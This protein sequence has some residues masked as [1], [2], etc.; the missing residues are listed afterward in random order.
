M[1]K[2]AY[3]KGT[4]SISA[5]ETFNNSVLLQGFSN[6][7]GNRWPCIEPDYSSYIDAKQIR[8]MSRIIRMSVASSMIA[9]KQAAI[10]KPDAV[11][12]GTAFGC[13]GDTYSFLSKL[14]QYKEDMLSPTAFI[15]STHN[16][17]ASQIALHYKCY[18]YNSTYVHRNNSYESALSDALLMIENNEV[19]N[20][21]VGGSDETIDAGFTIMNRMGFFKQPTDV[22]SGNLF[23]ENNSGTVA[24]EG[25]S[26]FAL[27][28][29]PS[30]NCIAK[31]SAVASWSFESI[32]Q[33]KENIDNLLTENSIDSPSIVL[34]GYNGSGS[35]LRY[36]EA[37]TNRMKLS[38]IIKFKHLC[39]EY[40]TSSA[41]ATWL[42]SQ[43]LQ[44]QYT[45]DGFEFKKN[46]SE[47]IKS[48]LIYNQTSHIHH[49]VILLEAC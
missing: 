6:L 40:G 23:N 30:K 19:Q 15:H 29:D 20:V 28:N 47:K 27:T 25:C 32:D 14:V 1:I 8:R 41:F 43:M 45:L 3:I 49:S 34:T 24:G 18:G 37:F 10:E 36:E 9:L 46:T 42:A 12:V 39:G 17:I 5:Q 33:V 2:G 11:I 22:N 13:L 26:F 48:I 4:C 21:L 31:I 35:E 7:E 16:T 38:R 44:H